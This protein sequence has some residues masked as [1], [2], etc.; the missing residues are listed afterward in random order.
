MV[1]AIV[2]VNLS[3]PAFSLIITS[4]YPIS[5]SDIEF[6]VHGNTSENL[7]EVT[8]IAHH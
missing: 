2:I 6:V 7:L 4:G 5:S 8:G 1:S 3:V